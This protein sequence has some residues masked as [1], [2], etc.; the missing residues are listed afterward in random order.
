MCGYKKGKSDSPFSYNVEF[1]GQTLNNGD[2]SYRT[3]IASSCRGIQWGF[4]FTNIHFKTNI[5]FSKK[6]FTNTN[7]TSIERLKSIPDTALKTI[8]FTQLHFL[9]SKQMAR[10]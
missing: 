1:Y 7:E 4:F 6:E 3:S 10:N 2:K 9:S 5:D 8:H